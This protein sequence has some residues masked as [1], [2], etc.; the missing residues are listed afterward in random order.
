MFQSGDDTAPKAFYRWSLIL[1]EWL[2]Q[3]SHHTAPSGSPAINGGKKDPYQAGQ[4]NRMYTS[5][6]NADV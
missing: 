4:D 5:L 3:E 1:S 2:A 6:Y